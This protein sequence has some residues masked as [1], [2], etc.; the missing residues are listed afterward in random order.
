MKIKT[1]SLSI[2]A[3]LSI[4]LGGAAVLP[5]PSSTV[6]I[7]ASAKV[8]IKD[9]SSC[10]KPARG[11]AACL[12]IKRTLFLNG[13]RGKIRPLAT[14]QP[15]GGIA[16]GANQLRKAYGV[17]EVGARYKVIAIV[18]AY[19]SASAYQDLVD[20]RAMYDLGPI[21]N[22]TRQDLPEM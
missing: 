15:L 4:A 22:C 6:A 1:I 12:A 11:K 7:A 21:D 10:S 3:A 13:V 2:V 5:T 17:T 8:S 20:Y 19:H 14:V 16:Y 9:V 18:D